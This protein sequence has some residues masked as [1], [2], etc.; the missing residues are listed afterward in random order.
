MSASIST[1]IGTT[2]PDRIEVRGKDIAADI[3][4]KFDFIDMIWW[5]VAGRMPEPREKDMLNM[6]LVTGADHGLTPSAISARLTY[7]GA[8]ESL[9]GAVAAGLLG[10]GDRFLG[11]IQNAAETFAEFAKELSDD[12]DDRAV[13]EAARRL[14]AAHRAAGKPIPGVGHPL[15]VN[16]D[17]RIPAL[18]DVSR[19][20]G[21]FGRHWR[22]A[23]A[24]P[25]VLRAELGRSLPLNAAGG[26]GAA[27][28]DMGLPP[29]LGRGLALIG[30]TAGL[31]AH[32]LEERERPIGQRIWDL[33]LRQD[34]RNVLP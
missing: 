17:P 32:L 11:T 8:P 24:L 9:Q 15:H 22:L 28:A 2:T 1:D 6:F 26:V 23:L 34:S 29:Q 18:V 4:G 5:L 30:R 7:L 13:D 14:I 10:A 12:A 16:G 3:I 25:A 19:R 20:N 31:V 33:V 27:M 21:Y